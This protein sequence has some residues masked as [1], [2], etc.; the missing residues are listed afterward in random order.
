M[1]TAQQRRTETIPLAFSD[2][3]K[4]T[5]GERGRSRIGLRM[6]MVGV[7]GRKENGRKK[8]SWTCERSRGIII[9]QWLE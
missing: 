4:G 5:N 9:T 3:F 7:V 8:E 1:V 2:S 6:G